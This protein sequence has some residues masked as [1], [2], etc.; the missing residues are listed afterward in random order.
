MS[1]E[2]EKFIV[3]T[4]ALWAGDFKQVEKLLGEY[5]PPARTQTLDSDIESP[6]D[7]IRRTGALRLRQLRQKK[8][9]FKNLAREYQSGDSVLRSDPLILETDN[10]R[11]ALWRVSSR[12]F[13]LYAY[14]KNLDR[15]N[16]MIQLAHLEASRHERFEEFAKQPERDLFSGE[17]DSEPKDPLGVAWTV[18]GNPFLQVQVS[19][20]CLVE[21]RTIWTASRLPRTAEAITKPLLSL[22]ISLDPEHE[23]ISRRDRIVTQ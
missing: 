20:L 2:T 10:L 16:E 12:E 1:A 9:E 4:F 15:Q 3:A 5:S 17:K 8:G 7:L 21:V 19:D 23:S 6:E 11:S 22:L 14:L 18:A 13:H